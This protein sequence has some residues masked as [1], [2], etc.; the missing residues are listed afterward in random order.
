M[1][2][3]KNILIS[4]VLSLSLTACGGG[5][6]GGTA[7]N[8]ISNFIEEDLSNLNGS[9]LIISDYSNLISNFQNIV[10]EGQYSSLSAVVTGPNS[11]DI[12]KAN[13]LLNILNQTEQLWLQTEDLI[14]QQSDDN[15]FKIYNSKTY[16]DAYAAYLYL[17]ND[18]GPI[19]RIVSQGK[20]V[21]LSDYNKV[22]KKEKADEIIKNE[23]LPETQKIVESKVIKSSSVIK[24]DKEELKEY[25]ENP[26]VSY[27]NWST[28]YNGG[29]EEKRTKIT[30]TKN[31]KKIITK[32]CEF[33]RIKF[34]NGNIVDE[35][36]KCKEVSTQII[37]LDPSIEEEIEKR[38]GENPIIKKID[39][40]PIITEILE[41]SNQYTE[42]TYKDSSD[43]I[44]EIIEGS[45]ITETKSRDVE[46]RE[47]Q[48]NNKSLKIIKRYTDTI[49]TIPIVKKIYKTRHFTDHI[50]IKERSV[51]SKIERFKNIYKDGSDEVI[52]K[53]EVITYGDWKEIILNTIQRS[54]KILLSTIES[55]KKTTITDDGLIL[56]QQLVSNE[57]TNDDINLG[58]KTLNLSTNVND[59]ETFEYKS[60]KGLDI[61]NAAS[62]YARGWTGKGAVLGVIDT[63]QDIDHKE[64]KDKYLYFKNYDLYKN[65]LK[66]SQ[67][68]GTH[69]AGIIAGKKDGDEFFENGNLKTG[70]YVEDG[71]D[72]SNGG[73]TKYKFTR[74]DNIHGVAYDAKLV[75]ANVDRF[76][77]GMIS[78]GQAQNALEDFAKL[79][80]PKSAGGE[81]LNIVAVNMSFNS[82]QLFLN[83]NN[84]TTTKL[85]DGTFKAEELISKMKFDGEYI[86]DTGSAKY[87]KAATDNDIIIVNS[88]GNYGF[89]HAGDPGIW[90]TEVDSNGDLILGGKMVIVGNW[91]GVGVSGNK[92]GHVCLDINTSNN[93]CNDEYRISDFYILAPG[94][95]IY[96][97]VTNNEYVSLSGTSMSAPHVTGAFG[98]LNQMWPYMKGDNLV[99]LVMNTANKDLPNY[100]INIHGQGL[101]DLDEATK[102]QGAIGI[103]TSGRVEHPT[104]NLNN[105]YFSTGTALPSDLTNLNI[106]VLD[107]YDRNYYLNLGSTFSIQDK[108]KFSNIEMVS[109]NQNYFLPLNQMYGSFSQGAQ[110]D[111]DNNY[112]FG[113]YGGE[114]ANGD[115][116][117]NIGKDFFLN[118]NLKFKTSISHLNEHDTWLGNKS[119]GVLSVGKN[120]LTNSGSFGLDYLIKNN[121]LSFDYSIGKS[122]INNQSDSLIKSFSNIRTNSYRLAYK[123]NKDINNSYGWSISIPNYISKG[124]INLELAESI[125][126]D[127]SINYKT[128]KSD[129][130]SDIKEKNFGF[131]YNKKGKD[132]FDPSVKLVAE[133]RQDI[134]GQKDNNGTNVNLIFSK[135]VNFSCKFLWFRNPKC[136]DENGELKSNIFGNNPPNQHGL[137]YNLK[138]DKFE[139]FNQLSN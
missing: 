55:E 120:N 123:I 28:T 38:D 71:I 19:I 107:E 35:A 115:Y 131:F 78:K 69:V 25:S 36:P 104:V 30:K 128:I 17:V 94:N 41:K 110:Y 23:K 79:K 81:G 77:N 125:N 87:Y 13:N 66:I 101:L 11:E 57:Y 43:H 52:S 18:V 3:F 75:G 127:G 61:I 134:S 95:N 67:G 62:A 70:V 39:I 9:E 88:A 137:V 58:Q 136:F 99:K 98:I 14:L 91:N 1:N 121:V 26:E 105:T 8:T 12:K 96:S 44:E 47:N 130:S 2:K 103:P 37:E 34:L 139:P 132:I 49:T 10:S 31:F 133:Y 109:D 129:L 7:V 97:T 40:D 89:E 111:L 15:K 72:W 4:S 16:K 124:Q 48:G 76:S 22:A 116:L 33:K 102:P 135:K 45:G 54:E 24:E 117:F 100:N 83:R 53:D 114:N 126:L 84:S 82:P 108:R 118:N 90:A 65:T 59:H 56:S 63:Y 29:G 113:L 119:D 85:N 51:T 27:T 32:S 6:G 112:N 73:V 50:K 93:T 60:N 68:H 74:N 92:A 64:L 20:N 46:I 106:M 42:T 80:S 21:T 86:N 5:G 138:T 122:K